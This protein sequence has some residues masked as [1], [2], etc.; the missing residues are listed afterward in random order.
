MRRVSCE[1][2][3]AGRGE[4]TRERVLCGSW[5]ISTAQWRVSEK[6]MGSMKGINLMPEEALVKSMLL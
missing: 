5:I 3:L 4:M 2:M 1:V 6:E